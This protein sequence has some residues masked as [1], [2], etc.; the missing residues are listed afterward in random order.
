[1]KKLT[2]STIAFVFMATLPITAALAQDDGVASLPVNLGPFPDT[3]NM[4]FLGQVTPDEVGAL[5]VPGVWAKGMMN[6][7]GGWTSPNGEEYA[8][9]TNS[10]GIGFVRITDPRNPVYLG[11]IGSQDPLNFRNIWG[12]PA[13]FGNYG[14]FVTEIGDSNVVIVDLS[15]LDVLSAA[16]SPDFDLEFAG[17][18][19]VTT[20]NGGGY[21]GSHN[22]IVNEATG[23]GYLAGVHLKEGAA[24]NACGAAI[25]ARF[26]TLILDL[27]ADPANPP[28][29]AC[30][31]DMGEHDLEPVI[32]NGP[33]VEHAGK[34]ILYVFDG[35]DRRN[36]PGEKTGGLT[37]ILDV[38]NKASIVEIASFEVPG[39]IF[40]HNGSTTEEED[41]LF[42]SDELDELVLADWVASGVFAQ[43]TD[44]PTIMPATGTFIMDIRDLDN[45]VFVERFEHDTVGIDH[46][47][48]VKGDKL[49]LAAYTSGTRVLQITRDGDGVVGLTPYGHMDTEPRL[50]NN[51]L[52]IQQEERFGS[53]FLGQ[54]G[55]FAFDGS[56]TII[57]SD[58]NNGVIIMR[59][60]D[61]PCQG[62]VCSLD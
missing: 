6:D 35:R 12:D 25:P 27:D 15:G 5:P 17:L 36:A 11:K 31:G 44:D 29:V 54:W 9:A 56:D 22:V 7:I 62:M 46:N 41:F 59:L 47:F 60:S 23:Y 40:S 30:L 39:L 13:T 34:E 53:S 55:I 14:Y 32:Y 45:P 26:N 49:I 61:A 42:I 3:A 16:P 50:P 58:L 48:V 21:N 2:Q 57:A 51:I 18:L 52:N 19:S 33:D 28:V 24:N 37:K 4:E 10:G 38:S 20:F 1:M 43:P 8:L